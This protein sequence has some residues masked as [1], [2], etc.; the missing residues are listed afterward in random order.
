MR[1]HP[2]DAGDPGAHGRGNDGPELEILQKI[3][4]NENISYKFKG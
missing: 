2:G 1:L 4:I 3:I